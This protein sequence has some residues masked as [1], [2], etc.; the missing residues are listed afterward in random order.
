MYLCYN[1]KCKSIEKLRAPYA[2][3][4]ADAIS[5]RFLG[6]AAFLIT[7]TLGGK[8]LEGFFYA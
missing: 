3:V 6:N 7:T 1:I 4:Y 8:T 5:I 2:V